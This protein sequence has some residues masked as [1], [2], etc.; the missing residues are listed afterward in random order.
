MFP[1]NDLN[2][3]RIRRV[4]VISGLL[5]INLSGAMLITGKSKGFL[6]VA[7]F[8]SIVALVL[9]FEH[10]HLFFY[11]VVGYLFFGDFILSIVSLKLP[12]QSYFDEMFTFG[13]LGLFL[14]KKWSSR[15]ET[16]VAWIGKYILFLVIIILSSAIANRVPPIIAVNYLATFLKPIA[17]FYVIAESNFN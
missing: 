2:T 6:V 8:Y 9:Y 5:L 16:R 4:L 3:T 15:Q 12:M 17:L 14:L 10:P 1:I 13:L 11:F 7:G